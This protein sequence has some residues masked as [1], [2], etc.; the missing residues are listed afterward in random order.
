MQLRN[1]HPMN[2]PTNSCM[3]LRTAHPINHATLMKCL[4]FMNQYFLSNDA[5]VEIGNDIIFIGA[6]ATGGRTATGGKTATHGMCEF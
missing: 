6:S 3:Q 2:N 1:A 4:Q 5:G